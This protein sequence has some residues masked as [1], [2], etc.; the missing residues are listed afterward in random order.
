MEKQNDPMN[1]SYVPETRKSLEGFRTM[2]MAWDAMKK[3]SR[4]LEPEPMNMPIPET[5]PWLKQ[6]RTRQREEFTQQMES[7]SCSDDFMAEHIKHGYSNT[8]SNTNSKTIFYT[9]P[10]TQCFSFYRIEDEEKSTPLGKIP[11]LRTGLENDKK[12]EREIFCDFLEKEP[13]LEDILK[14]LKN[15]LG[16]PVSD[17]LRVE[18]GAYYE[19]LGWELCLCAVEEAERRGKH[20]WTS[21]RRM[22]KGLKTFGILTREEAGKH[23]ESGWVKETHL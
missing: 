1:L 14:E 21:V 2:A 7:L 8:K 15:R 3:S 19:S 4:G 5:Y 9:K 12:I 18:M 23:F 13:T 11:T 17:M 6:E 16:I 22:L 10:N 20:T